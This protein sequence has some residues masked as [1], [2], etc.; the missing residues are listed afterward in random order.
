[1]LNYQ[2]HFLDTLGHLIWGEPFIHKSNVSGVKWSVKI[3]RRQMVSFVYFLILTDG[4]I[5]ICSNTNN[6]F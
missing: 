1:M 2:I 6:P 3:T 5:C 4:V